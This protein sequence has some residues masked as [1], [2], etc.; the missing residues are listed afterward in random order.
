MRIYLAIAAICILASLLVTGANAQCGTF[1][2]PLNALVGSN[3]AGT[4]ATWSYQLEGVENIVGAVGRFTATVGVDPRAP[5][6][7]QG[8]VTAT[9]TTN[10]GVFGVEQ[11]AQYA[12][13]Y[14]V[15]PD[16]SGGTIMLGSAI[17]FNA[18]SSSNRSYQFFFA[19]GFSE[20]YLIGVDQALGFAIVGHATRWTGPSTC[21]VANPLDIFNGATGTTTWSY[22]TEGLLVV[23]GSAGRFVAGSGIDPRAPGTVQGLMTATDSSVG[24]YIHR[25]AGTGVSLNATYQGKDTVR[26]DCSG[27]T[28]MLG[29]MGVNNSARSMAFVFSVDFTQMYM[30][31]L[32]NAGTE[33]VSI[34]KARQF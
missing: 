14:Q 31:S 34:G 15:F 6:V 21:P 12:G 30:V 3:V 33:V 19:N 26:P 25:I 2:D 4:T 7:S 32:D 29:S 23:F 24:Y 8:L 18:P 16:C 17:S 10:N 22:G 20:M 9:Q 5:G 28:I 13:K 27:G 1:T 11:L